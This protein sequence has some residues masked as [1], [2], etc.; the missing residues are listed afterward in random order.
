M[1]HRFFDLGGLR[2]TQLFDF[3]T[4]KLRKLRKVNFY[5]KTR[6]LRFLTFLRFCVKNDV[7]DE[8]V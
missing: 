8:N 4:E 2:P 3:L 6:F 7:F 1:R 5:Q